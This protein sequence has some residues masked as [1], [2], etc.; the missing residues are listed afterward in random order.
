MAQL[1]QMALAINTD[2]PV[3]LQPYQVT[4]HKVL[5]KD[6]VGQRVLVN[7]NGANFWIIN[8]DSAEVFVNSL[9]TLVLPSLAN[10]VIVTSNNGV[11]TYTW[12]PNR[13]KNK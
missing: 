12:S 9:W 8:V 6:F 3:P 1:L 5:L 4:V 2:T 10:A 11:M 13:P 7:V